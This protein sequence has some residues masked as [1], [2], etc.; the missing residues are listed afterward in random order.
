LKNYKLI[1]QYD[2]TKYA[3]WQIQLNALSVQGVLQD[4]ISQIINENIN[5]IGAGRT[6]SGVHSLGQTANFRTKNELDLY[7]FKHSLNSVLPRDITVKTISEV[8]NDFHAR[9]DAVKRSYIYVISKSKSPFYDK[10]SWWYHGPIN[11]D[12]LN[13][14]SEYLLGEKNFTAF[15]R[16]ASETENKI[17]LVHNI[18]WKEWKELVIFYVEADRYLH[19]MVR[20][21]VGTL[22]HTLKLNLNI[23]YLRNVINSEDRESA[24][25]AVPAKGLFLYKVKY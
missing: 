8:E 9:Y 20:T 22:L 7:R 18:R 6:D 16:R 2:G 15:S 17:C 1:I 14:I 5:L 23:D 3:G 12:K 10:Y 21:I 13:S 4:S 19:G 11:C 24:G 25:E